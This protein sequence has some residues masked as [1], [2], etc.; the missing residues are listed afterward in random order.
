VAAIEAK[1]AAEVQALIK[2]K[3]EEIQVSALLW[4]NVQM[5]L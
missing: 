2:Q 4:E 3:E 5:L 1:H